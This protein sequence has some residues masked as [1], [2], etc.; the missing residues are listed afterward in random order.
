MLFFSYLIIAHLFIHSFLSAVALSIK[1]KS[2]VG[3]RE[4][5][6]IFSKIINLMDITM[7]IVQKVNYCTNEP[8]SQT[9][10]SYLEYLVFTQKVKRT[11]P[12]GLQSVSREDRESIPCKHPASPP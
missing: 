6:G 10:R 1:S 2:N 3:L 8:S 7:D 5:L 9:F 12:S 4:E 11:R